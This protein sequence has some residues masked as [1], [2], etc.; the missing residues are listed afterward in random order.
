MEPIIIWLTFAY[1][2]EEALEFY[3]TCFL[4]EITT[5]HKTKRGHNINSDGNIRHL[6]LYSEFVS[7]EICFIAS[8]RIAFESATTVSF[9]NSMLVISFDEF[10]RF[11]SVLKN[12]SQQGTIHKWVNFKSPGAAM[13]I[14]TDRF[15]ISWILKCTNNG[16]SQIF[17][18]GVPAYNKL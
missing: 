4:G 9:N 5:M 16:T 11:N 12:L 18:S 17:D 6:I 1:K 13:V 2:C 8:D 15:D 14:I 3:K 10:S 7:Q